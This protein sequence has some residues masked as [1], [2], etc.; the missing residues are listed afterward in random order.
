VRCGSSSFSPAPW[1]SRRPPQPQPQP[2]SIV[3]APIRTVRA[4]QGTIGY[5]DVGHGR[6]LILIMGLS[7]TMDSWEPVFADALARHRRVIAFDNEGIRRTTL[8]PGTLTIRR[9][10]RDVAS[11]ITALHLRRADVLGWSM[12]GMIAQALAHDR[13]KLVRRLILCATAPGDGTATF[14][15]VD[16][17][18]QLS[19]GA[20]NAAGLLTQLFPP[21]RDADTQQFVASLLSYPDPAT[22]APDATTQ[23]Q[24]A[25]ATR[26][27]TGGDPSGRPLKRLALPVLVGGG[28]LDAL[29]PVANQRRL[30][31][32]LPHS[33]LRIYP[34]AAHGFLFQ[35]RIAFLEQIERFLR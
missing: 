6:P 14:P 5:R 28:A 35:E 22:I 29:L 8:G 2:P 17:A 13:P 19:G 15:A 10:G 26:W 27:L 31:A 7:G 11:L 12:G 30:A 3:K 23:L 1:S 4:G 24:L 21:G 9:M 33:R 18:A 25:A 16:L 32:A 34:R 20:A